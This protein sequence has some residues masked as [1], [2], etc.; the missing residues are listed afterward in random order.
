MKPFIMSICYVAQCEI[1]FA[2][3]LAKLFR[4]LSYVIHKFTSVLL[5]LTK[6]HVDSK[7]IMPANS[8]NTIYT[9]ELSSSFYSIFTTDTLG[10]LYYEV[11]YKY[12]KC[13]FLYYTIQF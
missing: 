1:H 6:C 13:E 7:F 11:F 3:F 4:L 12:D 9:V 8:N 10:Q 2:I 5:V